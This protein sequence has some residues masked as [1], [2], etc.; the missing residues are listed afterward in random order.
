MVC[1]Y[2]SLYGCHYCLENNGD[3]SIELYHDLQHAYCCMY[4]DYHNYVGRVWRIY[5]VDKNQMKKLF[6][7]VIL[8]FILGVIFRMWFSSLVPQPFVYDQDQYYGFALGMT[9]NG[10]HADAY[11]LYG[12]PLLI[13]PLVYFFGVSS[14]VPWTIV[15]ALMDAMTGVL[16]FLI[17]RKIFSS[18]LPHWIAYIAYLFNPFTSAYVGVLLS[19]ITAIFLLTLV[20]YFLLLIYER[21]SKL[22]VFLVTAFLLGYLPQVRPVFIFFTFF[23]VVSLMVRLYASKISGSRKIWS[24]A[25]ILFLYALPYTY[26][27]AANVRKFHQIAVMSV[28]NVFIR[29]LYTSL[30][31]SR[32]LP[33]TDTRWGVWPPEA[34]SAWGEYSTPQ[35]AEGRKHMA[36]KYLGLAIK[37]IKS[38]PGWYIRSRIAKMGY[39]WEK[40]FL[41][42]YRVES[43]SPLVKGLVYWGNIILLSMAAIGFV[44]WF[45]SLRLHEETKRLFA[46]L[47]LFLII[48]ISVVHMISTSEERFSLPAYP[49][50]ILYA[51]Y[52][53]ASVKIFI[54][55]HRGRKRSTIG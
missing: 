46:T 30:Y 54:N 31:I 4:Y 38:D 25:L 9:K 51:G 1:Y 37:K 32:A 18:P 17:A 29:E 43:R 14:P 52:A 40:H 6:P 34:L 26:T 8:L 22:S 49:I 28:D 44:L 42:P 45:R 7:L 50:I 12:Y 16:V 15:H 5:A 21:T 39:V 35:D 41:F 47:S 19:E 53:V 27:V 24:I 3:Y 11:R 48:Y 23:C 13:V 20:I 36:A 2:C 33:F 10:L 55:G